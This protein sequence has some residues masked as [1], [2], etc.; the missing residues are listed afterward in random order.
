MFD[1]IHNSFEGK[2]KWF[3][4]SYLCQRGD[5]GSE[6]MASQLKSSLKSDIK[7]EAS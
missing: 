4:A 3:L 7:K 6:P 2:A 5:S 1:V